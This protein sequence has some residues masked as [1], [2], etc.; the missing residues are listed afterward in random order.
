VV[1]V[2]KTVAVSVQQLQPV[3]TPVQR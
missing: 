1:I 2:T 3:I